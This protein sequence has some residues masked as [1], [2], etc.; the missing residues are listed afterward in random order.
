MSYGT[1][2]W[3]TE[4]QTIHFMKDGEQRALCGHRG[5]LSAPRM[6]VC[7]GFAIKDVECVQCCEKA[8]LALIDQ[9]TELMKRRNQIESVTV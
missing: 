3:D 4:E 1:V 2:Y 8:V 6:R 7:D 9:S 5:P